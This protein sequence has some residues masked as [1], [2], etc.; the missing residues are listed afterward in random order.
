MNPQRVL[1]LALIAFSLSACT[2]PIAEQTVNTQADITND[3]ID[4]TQDA[5]RAELELAAG[6]A[7]NGILTPASNRNYTLTR[8]MATD[9][10]DNIIVVGS[11]DALAKAYDG[12]TPTNR[13]NL[14][15]ANAY[16]EKRNS[17]GQVVWFRDLGSDKEDYARAVSV[18]PSDRI[19]VAGITA[20]NLRGQPNA[21][22]QDAFVTV[23]DSSGNRLWTRSLGA[24]GDDGA[25]GV[26]FDPQG[27]VLMAGYACGDGQQ[28]KGNTIKG[29]CD[30]FLSKY[31]RNGDRA[32][33]RLYGSNGLDFAGNLAVNAQGEAYITGVT[34]TNSFTID[35]EAFLARFSSS[36][37]LIN[38][39]TGFVG[40]STTDGLTVDRNGDV[41]V[42]GMTRVPTQ[43]G[44]FFNLTGYLLKLDRNLKQKWVKRLLDIFPIPITSPISTMLGKVKTDLQGNIYAAGDANYGGYTPIVFSSE[45]NFI[46]AASSWT[47]D[48]AN[49]VTPFFLYAARGVYDFAITPTGDV[50]VLGEVIGGLKIPN[51][52]DTAYDGLAGGAGSFYFEELT[53]KGLLFRLNSSLQ[54]Q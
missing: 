48:I 18:G 21:G 9:S 25:T 26:A 42:T 32:W 49:Q 20:G 50:I 22:L 39:I 29:A 15:S 13:L 44:Q 51:N 6:P 54:L 27:N 40:I 33:T 10:K 43:G 52:S 12:L 14:P 19:A 38:A 4:T 35:G 34:R 31:N 17:S 5:P 37:S 23:Y 3:L 1:I 8:A 46:K 11:S 2:S 7:F 45:G 28:I 24:I 47:A 53:N 16:I 36:G 30:M 41:I